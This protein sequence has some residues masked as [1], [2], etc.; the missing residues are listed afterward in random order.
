MG[1][2]E[3]QERTNGILAELAMLGEDVRGSLLLGASVWDARG[4]PRRARLK[5]SHSGPW[6]RLDILLRRVDV[7]C[8]MRVDR[9]RRVKEC[10]A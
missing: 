6:F 5:I 1:W 8:R 4:Y 7:Y 3:D 2:K 10:S 9:T